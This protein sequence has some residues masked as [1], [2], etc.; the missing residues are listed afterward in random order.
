M[1]VEEKIILNFQR[2]N[3]W[4]QYFITCNVREIDFLLTF[5][6]ILNILDFVEFI[7]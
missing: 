6:D 3:I 4:K 5:L 1:N 7:C 2:N